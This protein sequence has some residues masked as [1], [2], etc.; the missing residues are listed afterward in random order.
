MKKKERKKKPQLKMSD[1]F[2]ITPKNEVLNR[3]ITFFCFIANGVTST[4]WNTKNVVS[5]HSSLYRQFF[6]F[7]RNF[8]LL[9]FN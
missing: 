9:F 2:E 3:P 8:N 1:H 5:I 6:S 7:S 4:A